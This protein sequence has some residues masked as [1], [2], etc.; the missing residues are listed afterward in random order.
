[1]FNVQE[2]RIFHDN[3]PLMYH[4]LER[5]TSITSSATKN[6]GNSTIGGVGLLLRPLELESLNSVE[7]LS[8]RIVIASFNGN[9]ALTVIACYSPVNVSDEQDII[10]FTMIS[11][12]ASDLSQTQYPF[13][14]SDLNAH[15]GRDKYNTSFP[16]TIL[17]I[18]MAI[19]FRAC[20]KFLRIQMENINRIAPI[21]RNPLMELSFPFTLKF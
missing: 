15:L 14:G 18:E 8:S 1:M 3:S 2:H 7:K 12:L 11:P 20:Q 9:L 17:E 21:S 16:T 13:V 5:R 19:I 6:S 10:N 4:N